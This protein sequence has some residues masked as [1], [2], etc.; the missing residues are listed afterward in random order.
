MFNI[1]EE[2]V[3]GTASAALQVDT[4]E[5]FLDI[6]IVAK[7]TSVVQSI[8]IPGRAKPCLFH[9]VFSLQRR[10][11]SVVRRP[12]DRKASSRIE[13][14][15]KNEEAHAIGTKTSFKATR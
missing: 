15:L 10:I 4:E 13:N 7:A 12:N 8:V 1:I 14:Q 11:N 6:G 3:K 5:I 9:L 2:R